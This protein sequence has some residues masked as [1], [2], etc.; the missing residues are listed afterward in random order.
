MQS[1]YLTIQTDVRGV[2]ELTLDRPDKHNAFDEYIIADMT[3]A[4][5]QIAAN[6]KARVMLLSAAGKNFSAGADINWMRRMANNSEAENRRDADALASLLY[7]LHSLA[8]PTIAKVQGVTMGGGC[9]L[10]SCCDM[11]IASDDAR[12]AFSEARI[13]LVPATISPYVISRIG[14]G[15]ARR[16]FLTAESFDAARA[17]DIGLIAERVNAEELDTYVSELI[18]TLLGNSPHAVKAAKQLVC[19]IAGKPVTAELMHYTSELIAD[20]RTSRDG[21]EGLAAF[22]EKRTPDWSG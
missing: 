22:L 17:R 14:A 21:R 6:D 8:I 19:D 11:A 16:Y 10:V 1:N 18:N 12:F 4:L 5:D 15:H 9:G 3:R 13:G 2:V 7:K 20:I